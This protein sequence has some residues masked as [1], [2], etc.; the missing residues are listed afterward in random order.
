[1]IKQI[2]K[3]LCACVCIYCCLWY[4]WCCDLIQWMWLTF[5]SFRS[6]CVCVYVCVC[7]C[8]YYFP[9]KSEKLSMSKFQNISFIWSIS[10]LPGLFFSVQYSFQICFIRLALLGLFYQ[11]CYIR[12]ALSDQIYRISFFR[13]T[14]SNLLYQI[15][16][17]RSTLLD[18]LYWIRFSYLL[19][20]I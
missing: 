11:I 6:V 7:A 4:S 1:M 19:Y 2:E 18:L 20:Q 9:L 13:S 17:F 5:R 16:F 15:S 8:E 14:L 10:V 12:S 3:S